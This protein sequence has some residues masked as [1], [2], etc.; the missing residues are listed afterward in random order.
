MSTRVCGWV[1]GWVLLGFVVVVWEGVP[2]VL[3]V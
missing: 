3:V 2:F 1:G